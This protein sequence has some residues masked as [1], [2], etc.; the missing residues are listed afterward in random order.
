MPL[1]LVQT[2][3]DQIFYPDQY[4]GSYGACPDPVDFRSYTVVNIYEHS[5]AYSEEGP[6]RRVPRPGQRDYL[7]QLV[8][9]LEQLNQWE[10]ALGTS[11]R[12]GEQWDALREGFENGWSAF[13]TRYDEVLKKFRQP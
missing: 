11:G 5:N 2:H 4:N 9:T 7:G 10:L 3:G 13:R 8:C 6:W 1:P 12:S